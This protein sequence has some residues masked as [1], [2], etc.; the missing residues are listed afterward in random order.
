MRPAE[1]MAV[2]VAVAQDPAVRAPMLAN[3]LFSALAGTTWYMQFFFYTMGETQMG[4]YKFSSWTL[5]MA[6]IIIF[7]TLW[8][9]ALKEWKGAGGR[10][11]MTGGFQPVGSGR[12]DGHC[13]V[14]KLRRRICALTS[15]DRFGARLATCLTRGEAAERQPDQINNLSDTGIMGS[16]T[17]AGLSPSRT[18]NAIRT[19]SSAAGRISDRDERYLL[20]IRVVVLFIGC[21]LSR[22]DLLDRG[23]CGQDLVEILDIHFIERLRVRQI[24]QINVRGYNL[25]EIHA[26]FFKVVEQIAHGLPELMGSGGGIDAAVRSG[27]EATLGGAIQSLTGENT[28]TRRWAGWH[29]LGTNGLPLLQVAHATPVY[30]MWA[31]PGRLDTSMVARAGVLPNS[32]RSA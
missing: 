9:I 8:G 18:S 15:P 32:K 5:H 12:L 29:V 4:R 31:P 26:G 14:R 1:E 17:C 24:V 3:Y 10:T 13:G 20:Q 23:S 11:R 16:T 19:C 28:R 22:S 30:S 21:P 6:S 2:A 25:V 7:S 27:N